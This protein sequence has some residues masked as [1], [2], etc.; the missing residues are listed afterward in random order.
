MASASDSRTAEVDKHAAAQQI[1]E[2]QSANAR[3]EAALREIQ[4]LYGALTAGLLAKRALG[5]SLN[6]SEAALLR[7][8]R[9]ET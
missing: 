2:L 3:M 4:E 6:A 9:R 7:D 1:R 8:L 5:R